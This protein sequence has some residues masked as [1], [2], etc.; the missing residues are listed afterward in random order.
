MKS[1]MYSS[2]SR[3]AVLRSNSTRMKFGD[4]IC[5]HIFTTNIV[6]DLLNNFICTKEFWGQFAGM[7]RLRCF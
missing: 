7:E 5:H 6:L 4:N 2:R 1:T 3:R